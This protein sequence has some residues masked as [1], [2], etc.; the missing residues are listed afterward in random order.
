MSTSH[1]AL[2]SHQTP[3]AR[4]DQKSPEVQRSCKTKAHDCN[5]VS[6]PR[7]KTLGSAVGKIWTAIKQPQNVLAKR[8]RGNKRL[9]KLMSLGMRKPS[10]P[11]EKPRSRPEAI[12][13][14]EP[15]PP[16]ILSTPIVQET[17]LEALT[18]PQA[19]FA[20]AT[21]TDSS[22]S[23]S[24]QPEATPIPNPAPDTRQPLH[25][26]NDFDRQFGSDVGSTTHLSE[27]ST[28]QNSTFV[29]ESRS[30]SHSEVQ[31]PSIEEP[32]GG[33]AIGPNRGTPPP[34]PSESLRPF[35]PRLQTNFGQLHV[36]SSDDEDSQSTIRGRGSSPASAVDFSGMGGHFEESPSR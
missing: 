1:K 3:P 27:A 24:S 29:N 19:P 32:N 12:S 31:L 6:P 14:A 10:T 28:L 9:K 5:G 20:V 7:L 16:P 18:R 2:P 13:V 26:I 21:S 36:P 17:A 8:L 25:L 33:S 15:T 35:T 11:R 4:P 30:R 23:L 22:L 34:F